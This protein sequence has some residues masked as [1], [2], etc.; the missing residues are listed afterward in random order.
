MPYAILSVKAFKEKA[1][2]KG[3]A[4]DCVFMTVYLQSI[5]GG[6]VMSIDLVD[7]YK[8]LHI[9]AEYGGGNVKKA[10][11]ILPHLNQIK[12]RSV[13]DYGCGKGELADFLEHAGIPH[14]ERYDP[15]I[16]A[17][18][19]KPKGPFDVL[20]NS[21]VLEHIPESELDDILQDMASMGPHAFYI[22]NTQLA[23]E[24]LPDG[25]NAHLT[26]KPAAWWKL[27]LEQFYLYVE[28]VYI[29]SDRH[30]AFKT[31][32]SSVALRVTAPIQRRAI[33]RQIRSYRA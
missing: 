3:P 22:V 4:L 11:Y 10:P 26:V 7:Q 2:E 17:F 24:I 13:I 30:V 20:I 18:S 14:V 31:W 33:K 32:P 29:K 9:K 28:S 16:A 1:P 21:C 15:A 19:V 23:V 27:R 8:E 5:L 12:A 6:R 25:R